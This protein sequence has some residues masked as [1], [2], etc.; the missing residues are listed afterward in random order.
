MAYIAWCFSRSALLDNKT[1]TIAVLDNIVP[2][3]LNL[4]AGGVDHGSSTFDKITNLLFSAT[5][6]FCAGGGKISVSSAKGGSS[7]SAG[8]SMDKKG[9]VCFDFQR[10]QCERGLFP[11]LVTR[12]L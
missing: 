3:T 1:K 12:G 9:G 5:T 6:S 11:M 10:G 4:N 8:S 2:V 7:A